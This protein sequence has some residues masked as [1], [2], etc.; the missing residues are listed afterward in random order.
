MSIVKANTA[1]TE[2]RTERLRTSLLTRLHTAVGECQDEAALLTRVIQ[3]A[4]TT[5]P[6]DADWFSASW[7]EESVELRSIETVQSSGK[8]ETRDSFDE[9]LASLQSNRQLNQ[10]LSQATSVVEPV[11]HA[12]ESVWNWLPISRVEGKPVG[13]LTRTTAKSSSTTLEAMR[14]A[15][16][17]WQLWRSSRLNQRRG[18]QA[19]TLRGAADLAAIVTAADTIDKSGRALSD[20]IRTRFGSS[21]A[22]ITLCNQ[23]AKKPKACEVK[24][25]SGVTSFD[26]H[27]TLIGS[28]HAHASRSLQEQVE[29]T[30]CIETACESEEDESTLTIAELTRCNVLASYPIVKDEGQPVGA[31]TIGWDNDHARPDNHETM[32]RQISRLLALPLD[33][34][35]MRQSATKEGRI[36]TVRGRLGRTAKFFM[37]AVVLAICIA[38]SWPVSYPVKCQTVAQPVKR[39]FVAA[40]FDATLKQ[41]L[42]APGDIVSAGD[43]LALIDERELTL[44]LDRL[45]VEY[46]SV[47]K[48][49]DTALAHLDTPD[50]QIAELE[51]QRLEIQIQQLESKIDALEVKAPIDG[52]VVSGDHE[53][54]E[55]API[56]IGQTRFEI[57]PLD[58]MVVEVEIPEDEVSL[59][60]SR[61][62]TSIR[63]DAHPLQDW[64]LPLGRIQPRSELRNEQHVFIAEIMLDNKCDRIRP[65]MH[66]TAKIDGPKR[67]FAWTYLRGPYH[68][69]S[70]ALGW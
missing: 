38:G 34:I 63:F 31:V 67:P 10:L 32:S 7:N 14:L 12:P 42:V 62:Q 4:S 20:A 43:T 35:Q 18:Q 37:G 69:L 65:G 40:P 21:F 5:G 58:R 57:A 49:R 55:Q 13:L 3:L 17:F 56:Q 52:V 51:M 66:G 33:V 22:A 16:T 24:W 48:G 68:R 50:K 29:R 25:I 61:A 2:L 19:E 8:Q 53:K 47:I 54:S 60:R 45:N 26:R 9:S 11:A 6:Q 59:V 15:A 1:A 39:R 28:L 44:E 27:S 30:L 41:S 46:H 70:Q 36:S 23:A 64:T